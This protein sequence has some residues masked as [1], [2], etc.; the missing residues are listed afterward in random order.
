MEK[1]D[2]TSLTVAVNLVLERAVSP[3]P[4]HQDS[5]IPPPPGCEPLSGY[6][7]MLFLRQEHPSPRFFLGVHTF[8]SF[9]S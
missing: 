3:H 4:W 1:Q 2:T 7:H 5:L 6:V 9:L 8:K